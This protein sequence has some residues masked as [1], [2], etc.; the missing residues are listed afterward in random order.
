MS[1]QRLVAL[2]GQ[3]L[4]APLPINGTRTLWLAAWFVMSANSMPQ[5]QSSQDHW[6]EKFNTAGAKLVLKE[7]G[8]DHISGRT[9]VTYNFFVSGLPRDVSYLLWARLVGRAAQPVAEAF[10]NGDGKLVSR[11]AIAGKVTEDP[12]NLRVFAGRGEPK[13]FALIAKDGRFQVFGEV[14]PFPIEAFDGPCHLFAVMGSEAYYTV[15]IH[16][17]GL[18]TYED[19]V[20]A[21]QSDGEQMQNRAKASDLGTYD[22]ALFPAVKGKQSGKVRFGVMGKSCKLAIELPWGEGSYEIQ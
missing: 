6:G 21:S 19:L 15:W 20:I 12:I 8:R 1:L 4:S 10:L 17:T 16:V 11:P 13:Q 2:V 22:S 5:T 7:I 3:A 18:Q 9:V 14:I